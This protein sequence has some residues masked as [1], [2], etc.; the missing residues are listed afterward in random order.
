MPRARKGS[1]VKRKK[2]RGD[3]MPTGKRIL[4]LAALVF[5]LSNPGAVIAQSLSLEKEIARLPEMNASP[6]PKIA[7]TIL[8]LSKKYPEA[9]QK[10]L[11]TGLPDR[12]KYCT[13]L[14]AVYWLLEDKREERA[15][16]ILA[17]YDL[18]KLLSFTWLSNQ[19]LQEHP[20]HQ[21]AFH[22]RWDDFDTVVDRL[23]SPELIDYY[24]KRYFKYIHYLSG[25]ASATLIF[26]TKE[27]NCDAYSAFTLLCL[28]K[29]G[30]NAWMLNPPRHWTVVLKNTDGKYYAL[31]NARRVNGKWIGYM[32]PF[33]DMKDLI[34]KCRYY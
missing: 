24:E 5:I 18:K 13:P 25:K 4:L 7:D 1:K 6:N 23:N 11:N 28:G 9:F 3:V 12:R 27:G 2:R 10:M 26:T 29:A 22:K 17:D 16:Q 34:Q 31:D 19:Y 15:D 21:A 30:Y 33:D 20:E 8:A 14:Q 32:G